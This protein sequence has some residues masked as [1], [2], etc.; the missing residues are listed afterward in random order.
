MGDPQAS[1]RARVAAVALQPRPARLALV[2]DEVTASGPYF[3]AASGRASGVAE[4]LISGGS[5]HDP[6]AC[7]RHT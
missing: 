1:P 7:R 5:F 4:L 2:D 3:L 6:S